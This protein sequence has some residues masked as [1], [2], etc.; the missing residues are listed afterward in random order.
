M[1]VRSS[2]H[3]LLGLPSSIRHLPR[4]EVRGGPMPPLRLQYAARYQHPLLQKPAHRNTA[5]LHRLEILF[6]GIETTEYKNLSQ[7]ALPRH[8]DHA[9]SALCHALQP[10]RSCLLSEV[11]EFSSSGSM[12][13]FRCAVLPEFHQIPAVSAL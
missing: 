3:V 6:N 4:Q 12:P 10:L 8:L 13:A 9:S 2:Q 5:R 11:P 7:V 1:Q